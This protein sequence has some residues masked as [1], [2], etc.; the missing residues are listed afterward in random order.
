MRSQAHGR[1]P[2]PA[3]AATAAA[4]PQKCGNAI[5]N[6]L[7]SPLFT[8]QMARR[9]RARA[10]GRRAGV[11]RERDAVAG[12]IERFAISVQSKLLRRNAH[13]K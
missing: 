6:R 4:E 13:P 2:P 10:G 12:Q 11:H 5:M 3:P 7:K 8:A 1:P 9:R